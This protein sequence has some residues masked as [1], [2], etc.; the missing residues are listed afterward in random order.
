MGQRTAAMASESDH[1]T[2][3]AMAVP[4]DVTVN[5]PSPA[6]RATVYPVPEV[7]PLTWRFV[8]PGRSEVGK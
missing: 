8:P 7:R 1:P 5:A 3:S 4:P 6:C 2:L